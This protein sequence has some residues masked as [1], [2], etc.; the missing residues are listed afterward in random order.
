MNHGTVAIAVVHRQVVLIQAA[1]SHNRRDRW[2]DVYTYN[3]F[4]DGVFL[5]SDVPQARIA[6]S[7]LL[8][9]FPFRTTTTDMIEL[10]PRAFQEYLEL[11]SK[12]QKSYENLWQGRKARLR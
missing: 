3:L 11:S 12:Y 5:A 4:G 7:D 8:T 1:R 2:L 9:I 6:S 10:S